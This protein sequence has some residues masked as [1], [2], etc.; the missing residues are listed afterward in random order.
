MGA[1][2]AQSASPTAANTLH[3]LGLR[4]P[5]ALLEL[6]RRQCEERVRD[7]Q[8]VLLKQERLDGELTPLQVI[9]LRYRTEPHSVSLQWLENPGSARRAAYVRGR[10]VDAEGR[11]QAVI[12]P[13][14]CIARL[15]VQS[16]RVQVDGDLARR[17]SRQ[18]LDQV[19]CRGTFESLAQVHALAAARGELRLDYVG[20][21]EIDGRATY[22]LSRQLPYAD[23]TRGYPNAHLILHF[24]QEWLLPVGVYMFAD[25]ADRVLLGSYTMTQVRLNVGLD[26]QAFEF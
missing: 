15:F 4:D 18:T 9:H 22:V 2:W 21:G 7:Y 16:L 8:C 12:E 24:D 14:G 10:D 1:M 25:A 13:A 26:D 5:L 11:E 23:G 3:E 19:G 17:A 20:I 6:A